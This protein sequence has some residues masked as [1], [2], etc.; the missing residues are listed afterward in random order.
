MIAG[1]LTGVATTA[2]LIRVSFQRG[3][4]EVFGLLDDVVELRLQCAPLTSLIR[5]HDRHWR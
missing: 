1:R 3:V 5:Q 4:G 2:P